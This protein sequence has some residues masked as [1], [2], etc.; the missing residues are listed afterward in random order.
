MTP[1][2]V[3]RHFECAV[4]LG[5]SD[6]ITS[7][8]SFS[9]NNHHTAPV[10]WPLY[11]RDLGGFERAT[12]LAV[13]GA[14][15]RHITAS[16]QWFLELHRPDPA[17]TLIVVMWSGHDRDDDIVS[18]QLMI[19]NGH[20]FSYQPDVVTVYSGGCAEQDSGNAREDYWRLHQKYKTR[21][22]RAVENYLY[23]SSL[24]H[25]LRANSYRFVFLKYLDYSLPSR[26]VDF[27]IQ[28][29]LP[30]NLQSRWD[31]MINTDIAN[32]Y[33][34]CLRRDLLCDDDFH[35][36]PDGHLAWTRTVLLPYLS[37]QQ[38]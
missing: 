3:P 5:Y 11:L 15:N 20:D 27:D 28:P 23:I 16:T 29:Y 38:S 18:Q 6:L 10:S 22:S 13:C 8:C 37:S 17:T 12:N 1:S 24:Y 21:Q 19:P 32:I 25:Y 4:D 7:G 14:G 35:P 2:A 9:Y 30:L 34:W 31:D 36:S 26:T 33:Q